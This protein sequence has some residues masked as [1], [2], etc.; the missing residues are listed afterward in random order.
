MYAAIKKLYKTVETI[1]KYVLGGIFLVLTFLIFYTIICRVF[2]G[3]GIFWLEEAS[4]AVL[5]TTTYLCGCVAQGEDR[6]TKLSLLPDA[7]P[8]RASLFLKA[9][10][11]ALSAGF[12]FWLAKA[13]L[14]NTLHVKNLGMMTSSMGVGTWV[15]YAPMALGMLGLA[16]RLVLAVYECIVGGIREG[17]A[18][19]LT[20]DEKFQELMEKGE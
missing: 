1:E 13:A 16:L 14:D 9:F 19:K 18:G 11:S 3:Q 15:L 10:T 20:D 6:L 17:N 2:K 8:K 5:I 12:M 4:R 7:L